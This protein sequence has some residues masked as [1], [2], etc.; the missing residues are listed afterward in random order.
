MLRKDARLFVGPRAFIAGKEGFFLSA[1]LHCHT[2]LSNGSLGIEDLISLARKR[3]IKTIAITD[4]DCLAGT[5]RGKVIGERVGVNVIP[6]VELT[7]TDCTNGQEIHMLC[8]KPEFPDRLEGLCRRNSLTRKKAS[9][10]MMLKV[11]QRYPITP[12]FIAKCASGSTNIYK[13]HIMQAL[14]ETGFADRIFGDL[15]TELFSKDGK[16]SINFVPVYEDVF[17]VLTAIHDAGGIAVLSHPLDCKNKELLGK[18]VEAGLDGIEVYLPET[19]D[20]EKETLLVYAKKNKLLTTGGSNFKGLYNS[21][22]LSIGDCDLPDEC[23]QELVTYK[24]RRRK[25]Q[26]REAQAE[27]AK[28]L[29]EIIEQKRSERSAEIAA[30]E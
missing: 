20:D 1:D 16:T 4:H 11:A 26:R 28:K 25:Q 10:F 17:D 24:A 27:A 2:R 13:V 9:H 14:I 6:G 22:I 5:V 3:G 30:N 21:N 8:Y 19:T 15:Y 29:S 23:V 7:G 18:L 12:E